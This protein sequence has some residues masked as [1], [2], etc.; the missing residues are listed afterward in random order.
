MTPTSRRPPT[1]VNNTTLHTW[2]PTN[3][4]TPTTSPDKTTTELTPDT[5]LLTTGRDRRT[6]V[7]T[8]LLTD[9][10]CSTISALPTLPPCSA[11]DP[12]PRYVCRPTSDVPAVLCDPS[13]TRQCTTPT[14]TTHP[15]TPVRQGIHC[16]TQITTTTLPVT[17]TWSARTCADQFS[18][19]A[20]LL[21]IRG[22]KKNVFVFF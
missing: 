7:P 16:T 14:C 22:L 15:A 21:Q 19:A 2:E 5:T 9:P 13:T 8:T 1:Q 11:F 10:E 17:E 18:R 12:D 6:T 20:T 3:P 4:R